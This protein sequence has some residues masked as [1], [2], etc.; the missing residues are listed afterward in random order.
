MSGD[1]EL[2][3]Q[4]ERWLIWW[5]GVVAEASAT[6]EG[7]TFN[8]ASF[9]LEHTGGGCTAWERP[10][11]GTPWRILITDSEGLGHTLEGEHCYRPGSPDC[12]LIGAQNDDGDGTECEEADTA[13]RALEIAD[14]LQQRLK[15][16]DA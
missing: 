3:A 15:E 16:G 2:T 13:E 14:A 4:A 5:K 1:L 9:H 6:P 7:Q 10:V 12:W 11:D 8:A